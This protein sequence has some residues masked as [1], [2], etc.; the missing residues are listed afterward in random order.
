MQTIEPSLTMTETITDNSGT[1]D[2]VAGK[3]TYWALALRAAQDGGYFVFSTDKPLAVL[4][5]GSLDECV[6][7]VRTRIKIPAANADN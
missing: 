3:K 1:S 6:N 5:T 2:T 4:K 7:Y